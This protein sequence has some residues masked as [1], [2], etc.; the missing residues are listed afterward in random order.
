[1][2]D[3]VFRLLMKVWGIGIFGS[4]VLF[5]SILAYRR[6]LDTRHEKRWSWGFSDPWNP[7]NS[8]STVRLMICLAWPAFVLLIAAKLPGY[9]VAV[10]VRGV[11]EHRRLAEEAMEKN[12]LLAEEAEKERQK[13][14][15]ASMESLVEA[16]E[17]KSKR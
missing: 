2:T 3:V 4:T 16:V 8:D 11:R 9:A 1:M 6:N 15:A 5:Q 17:D 10:V 12:R 13:I 14:M 7:L